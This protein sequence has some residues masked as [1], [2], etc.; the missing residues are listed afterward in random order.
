MKAQQ[1][2]RCA[3]EMATTTPPRWIKS[4]LPT[5]IEAGAACQDQHLIDQ[6]PR[7]RELEIPVSDLKIDDIA[8]AEKRKQYLFETGRRVAARAKELITQLGESSG[9]DAVAA[10]ACVPGIFKPFT[11]THLSAR[12]GGRS[13]SIARILRSGRP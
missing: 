3:E 2:S 10:S 9:G 11:S 1:S 7:V 8:E 12:E 5:I 6:I 4:L 13:G